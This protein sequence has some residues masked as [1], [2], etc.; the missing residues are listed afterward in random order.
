VYV[1]HHAAN[2]PCHK[3]QG[4]VISQHIWQWGELVARI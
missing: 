1:R 2:V 3:G 4:S